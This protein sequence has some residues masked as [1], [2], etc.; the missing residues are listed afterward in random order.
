MAIRFDGFDI[1]G[2]LDQNPNLLKNIKPSKSVAKLDSI[3]DFNKHF[4]LKLLKN[5]M[6]KFPLER[7]P[8]K[9]IIE[10]TDSMA[11]FPS[12]L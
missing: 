9:D 11:E 5:N 10:F 4:E 6:D 3:D 1:L 7:T 8:D 12:V 2:I